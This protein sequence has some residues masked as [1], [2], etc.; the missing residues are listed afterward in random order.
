MSSRA[1]VFPAGTVTHLQAAELAAHPELEAMGSLERAGLTLGVVV[2]P[3]A[4]EDA[5]YRL[6][7]LPQRLAR[8]YRGLDPLDP[9]ED[10]V[11]EAE[12]AAMRLLGESY[13][14]DDLIDAIYASLAVLPTGV[15][16]RRPGARGP[17]VTGQRA[18]LL[19]I[20][21][22]FRDDWSTDAVLDRLATSGRLGVEA[23]P[24]VVHS[25]T[26]ATVADAVGRQVKAALGDDASIAV[27]E[28]GRV[29]RVLG[30]HAT[31]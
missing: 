15:E 12:Q 11:E 30:T 5:Y 22:I 18:A 29:T 16:V 31:D 23:R 8:L 13:L 17:S 21:G 2:L 20:K 25:G 10:I 9:D 14:L 6:N 1:L 4:V 24:I 27:D 7:N 26:A 19:A 28:L 3:G